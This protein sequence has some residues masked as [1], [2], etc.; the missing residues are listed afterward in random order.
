MATGKTET[1]KLLARRLSRTFLDMDEMI[2]SREKMPIA[3]IFESRG[4]P[5]FRKLEKEVVLEIS[6]KD[7]LVVACGGGTFVDPENV[8]LLKKS[9]TVI[10]LTSKPE[11]ILRRTQSTSQRPL[12]NVSDPEGKIEELISKR[13]SAYAVAHHIVDADQLTVE[14]TAKAVEKL[15]K[16]K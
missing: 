10:C 2:V 15:L 14:E 13:R 7:S 3:K 6:R 9:G 4:E 8:A 5:Y 11:T 16:L 12:L 1:A